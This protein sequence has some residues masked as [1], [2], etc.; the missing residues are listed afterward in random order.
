MILIMLES[1][2]ILVNNKN[3]DIIY[4]ILLSSIFLNFLYFQKKEQAQ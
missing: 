2:L 4:F 1:G 3:H